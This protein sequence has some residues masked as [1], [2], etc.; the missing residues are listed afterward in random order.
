MARRVGKRAVFKFKPFSR[1]QKQ[2]LT[3]WMPNSPTCD[4][5]GIIADGAIRAGKTLAMAMS[6]V[7]WAMETFENENFGMCGKTILSFR[8]N[9]LSFLLIV[10]WG[11]GYKTKYNRTDNVLEIRK[12]GRINH[13][14]IFGGKDEKSQDLIQG[15]TLAG[16]LFDEVALMP[17][18]F[19]NQATARCSVE[20]S[21]WWFNCNPAGPKHWFKINWIDKVVKLNL[22][23]LH[24]VMDD[25]LSLSEKTKERYRSMYTGVFWKRFIEGLWAV[26]D[27]VIYDMFDPETHVNSVSPEDIDENAGR[28]ISVDY[29]TQNAT[30]FHL[31]VKL[32]SGK[33]HSLKEYYHSGRESGQQKTDSQ[34]ADDLIDFIP[35]D[36]RGNPLPIEWVIVDPSAASFIAELK[37]RGL[38]VRHADNAVLDGIRLVRTLLSLGAIS[39]EETCTNTQAEFGTYA[40]D[41][42][43]AARGEDAPVK[44]ADHC[45]DSVRYFVQ[46]KV[47]K[48]RKWKNAA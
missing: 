14:W 19:V 42:K 21:K 4:R 39:F 28:F 41:E 43:A 30:V 11:R 48:E 23:H 22:L 3:W 18:S 25:N 31:W 27:G 36:D 1:K 9:V 47:R 35:K 37:T 32:M 24:F 26:A 10:L 44:E 46:T 29:G 2:I 16:C 38:V 12:N 13:F 40:W 45:M 5:D 6:F 17:E 20:G 34:Y 15:M 33:W 8:R 7:F